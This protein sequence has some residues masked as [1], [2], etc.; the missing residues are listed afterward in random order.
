MSKK[1]FFSAKKAALC[2]T[3][4]LTLAIFISLSSLTVFAADMITLPFTVQ[5]GQSEARTMLDMINNFRTGGKAW[6]WDYSD[7]EKISVTV[8]ALAYDYGL[9]Q[10]AMLRAA[11]IAVSCS[12]TRPDGTICFTAEVNGYSTSGENLAAGNSPSVITAAGAFEL[13]QETDEPYAGQ[14]HRRNMLDGSYTHVGIGHVVVDGVHYWTQEFGRS[15]SGVSSSAANDGYTTVN[16]NI[17][18]SMITNIDVNAPGNMTMKLGDTAN[19]PAAAVR[20]T[21]PETFP[22]PAAVAIIPEWTVSGNAVSV[23]GGRLS[24]KNVGRS[25]LSAS[26][27]G[28]SV[29]LTVDVECAVHSWGGWTTQKAATCTAAGVEVRSCTVCGN[30][31][32]RAVNAT[33]HKMGAWT[34]R[35][36]AACTEAGI[37]VQSCT[38]CGT[39]STR[40]VNATGHKMGD[41]KVVKEPTPQAEGLEESVCSVCGHKEQR[42]VAKLPP[43]TTTAAKTTPAEET[44]EPD[45]EGTAEEE[46]SATAEK[47][48]TAEAAATS[49]QV[50]AE[51]PAPE[52]TETP[53][54]TDKA[55]DN[56]DGSG[57]NTILYIALAAAGVLVIGGG[58]GAVILLRKRKHNK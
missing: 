23:D 22:Y 11:E 30:E 56:A 39:E 36:A 4:M 2:F 41:Y 47:T 38:V 57:D 1:R 34:T 9:E 16:V 40:T 50:A 28:K 19:I 44:T 3:V 13:L 33:G 14:G 7:S 27:Y 12:H 53:T 46:E 5:Y 24:A 25:T 17:N 29:S 45:T 20:I 54:D 42:A 32:T 31:E 6:Y 43:E 52:P 10:I 58:A 48:T 37:E 18:S 51:T 55:T 21:L 49:D 8:P 15:P 35:K 26:L